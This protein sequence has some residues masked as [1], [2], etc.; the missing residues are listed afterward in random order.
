MDGKAEICYLYGDLVGI[1][2]RLSSAE[3]VDKIANGGLFKYGHLQESR[4]FTWWVQVPREILLEK[5]VK[6]V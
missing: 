2:E 6:V 5:K 1:L 4:I 3:I